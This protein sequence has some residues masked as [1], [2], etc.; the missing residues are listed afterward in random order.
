MIYLGSP[1]SHF[2]WRVRDSRFRSVC[3]AAGALM[4]TSKHIFSPIAHCHPIAL[5]VDL[6]TTAEYWRGYNCD[7]LRRSDALW[8]LTLDGWRESKGL[9][10]EKQMAEEMQKPI[11]YVNRVARSTYSYQHL[12]DNKGA[13]MCS[14][15]VYIVSKLEPLDI[16]QAV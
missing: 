2:D 16:K 1:Y 8:I 15:F 7:T 12:E 11:R 6:P 9:D 13:P 14:E 10:I 3:R 4:K 5:E